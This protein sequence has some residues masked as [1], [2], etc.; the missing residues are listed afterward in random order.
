MLNDFERE[1]EAKGIRLRI[2]EARSNV[3][4]FLRI[5]GLEEKVGKIARIKSIADVLDEFGA[6]S[7]ATAPKAAGLSPAAAPV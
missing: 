3:R 5:E 7:P 1:L 6:N 4:D 2:V